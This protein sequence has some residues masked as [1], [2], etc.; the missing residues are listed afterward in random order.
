VVRA[1]GGVVWRPAPAEPEVVLVHR[2]R[3]DDWS[4]PK[5]KVRGDETDQ[6]CALREVLEE[7]GCVCIPRAELPSTSYVDG[8]GRQ[9]IVRYWLM[10]P[11][12]GTFRRNDEV[13]EVRW[14]TV[15]DGLELLSYEHDRALL[16]QTLWRPARSEAC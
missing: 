8:Q 10:R 11:L 4:F 3:Y 5:G 12:G 13:D 2:P 14:L 6:E 15:D 9:K 16:R 7:T 1:A